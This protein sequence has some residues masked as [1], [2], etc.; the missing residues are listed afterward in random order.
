MLTTE[1][2][3]EIEAVIRLLDGIST[4]DDRLEALEKLNAG[5]CGHCGRR[6]EAGFC[7]C[8]NDE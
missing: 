3:R 7:N 4:D 6:E 5:V 2:L 8:N 1:Q